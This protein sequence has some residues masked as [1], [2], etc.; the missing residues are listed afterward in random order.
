MV[1]VRLGVELVAI[2]GAPLPLGP[3][4]VPAPPGPGLLPTGLGASARV[5]RDEGGVLGDALPHPEASLVQLP[6]QFLIHQPVPARFGEALPELLLRGV[7]EDGFRIAQEP[8]EAEAVSRLPLQLLV[9]EAI[10]A[11][12][13]QKLNHHHHIYIRPSPLGALVVV[14]A[15]DDGSEG[16]PVYEAIHRCEPVAELLHLLVGLA[17]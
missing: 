10:P 13:H 8:P 12:E 5:G 3:I 7:V 6:L 2:H 15:G 4:A 17:E 9:R 1:D 16:L 14:E 11:L